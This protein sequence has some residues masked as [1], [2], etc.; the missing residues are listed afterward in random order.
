M[1]VML[2]ATLPTFITTPQIYQVD[3]DGSLQLAGINGNCRGNDIMVGG[4]ILTERFNVPETGVTTFTI[5][6]LMD[7]M[8]EYVIGP[9]LDEAEPWA[10]FSSSDNYGP[11]F[12]GAI[13]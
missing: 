6:V 11:C 12:I 10:D 2:E 8:S 5:G 1:F 9:L 7:H 13:Q 3:P 4:T